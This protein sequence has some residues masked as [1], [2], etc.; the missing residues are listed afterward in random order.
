M[1]NISQTKAGSYTGTGAA[2][3]ITLGYEPKGVIIMNTTDGDSVALHFDG[4]TDA[5][6]IAI[7][8]AAAAVASQGVTLT[9]RGFTLGTDASVNENAKTFAYLAFN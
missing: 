5:T 8:A 3:T 4:M 2:Q 9:S 6:A 7:G 1:G